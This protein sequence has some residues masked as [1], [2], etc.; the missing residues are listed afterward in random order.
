MG[1]EVYFCNSCKTAWQ[2]KPGMENEKCPNC[3]SEIIYS[4]IP[5]DIWSQMTDVQKDNYKS[6]FFELRIKQQ[7]LEQ[8]NQS[9]FL[10]KKLNM[11]VSSTS[12]LEGYEIIRF[13]DMVF[14]EI[15]IPNGLLGALTSGT[16]FTISAL[17]KARK[18]AMDALKWNAAKMGADAIIG[19]DVDIQDLNG[20]GMMV[21]ANGTA[22]EIKPKE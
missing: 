9:Q 17:D 10:H 22:V 3:K 20:R 18:K 7:D 1:A 13:I 21:S 15:V 4:G 2:V 11:I 12:T 14:G 6:E 8:K 16:F 19:V 5:V